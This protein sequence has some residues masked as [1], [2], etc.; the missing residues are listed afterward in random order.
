MNRE[1]LA[2]LILN[3][4]KCNQELLQHEI[5]IP[6]RIKSAVIDNLLPEEIAINIYSSFPDV[7]Q[8]SLK[9]SIKE[10]KF[11]AAQMDQYNSLLE[12]IIYAFQDKRIVD[13]FSTITGIDSLEPDPNLY[14][15]GISAMKKGGYLRPHIDNSHNAERT[16]YR[17]LNL[18]YYL[19]PN[20]S[21]ESG[22]SLQLWDDG[23]LKIRRSI[24]ASF[25]RLAVMLTN[26]LSWHSVDEIKEN[27]TRWC[28]SNYYFSTKSPDQVDYF[29]STSFRDEKRGFFDFAMRSDNFIRTL[30]LQTAPK[31]YKNPHRYI[32]IN[33][34]NNIKK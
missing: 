20:W 7:G 3:K 15:G 16:R 1:Q 32:R 10:Y 31:L 26:R 19:T 12:E 9:R 30:I 11:V 21:E 6:N 28:I 17:A 29:H 4:L 18:L 24:P 23:P 27:R 2:N 22:G 34:D 5:N 13:F 33:K 8:M 14:A 25:N